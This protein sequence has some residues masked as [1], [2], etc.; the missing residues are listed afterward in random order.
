MKNI[1]NDIIDDIIKHK[2]NANQNEKQIKI[3]IEDKNLC[4]KCYKELNCYN[5]SPSWDLDY[6]KNSYIENIKE[7]KNFL[8]N[9]IIHI[10]EE[11]EIMK[12]I[13]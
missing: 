10:K 9:N 4:E 5:N 12:N 13:V 6:L 8:N 2:E 7:I 1:I 3:D 11:D